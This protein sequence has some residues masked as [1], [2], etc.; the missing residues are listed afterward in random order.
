MHP[1]M[2]AN[3][4]QQ[5]AAILLHATCL[6]DDGV[7]IEDAVGQRALLALLQQS[8]LRE[9]VHAGVEV[10]P[11]VVGSCGVNWVVAICCGFCFCC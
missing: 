8:G 6:P 7:P 3:A 9:R 11:V 10:V 2:H 1:L 5:A 4:S